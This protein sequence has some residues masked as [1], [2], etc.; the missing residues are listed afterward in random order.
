MTRLD[1]SIFSISNLRERPDFAT[2]V[3]NRIW[4]AWWREENIPL[5]YIEGRV[6]ENLLTDAIPLGLVAHRE[7]VFMGTVSI[8]ASDMDERPQYTPWL[9]ALWVDVEH[10]G[11]GIGSALADAATQA[12]RS[13]GFESLYLGATAGNSGFYAEKGWRL[14]ETGVADLNIF[15]ID[16]EK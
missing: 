5:S 9:A 1:K 4:N 12:A 2:V 8:I 14:I 15:R 11:S 10:R 13:L 16:Q 3:A 6:A 7:T